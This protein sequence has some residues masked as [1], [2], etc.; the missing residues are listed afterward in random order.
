MILPAPPAVPN[1]QPGAGKAT[2]SLVLGLVGLVAWLIPLFGLPISIT[3]L[4]LGIVGL[5][6][7]RRGLAVAGVVLCAIVLVLSVINSAVG[8][9][10]GATGQLF[11]R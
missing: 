2:A 10:L 6:S 4:V 7:T 8:A 9:Y 5:K 11:N 1:G 3:G